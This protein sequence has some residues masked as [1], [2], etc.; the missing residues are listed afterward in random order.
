MT[1]SQVFRKSSELDRVSSDSDQQY[2]TVP[3][4]GWSGLALNFWLFYALLSTSPTSDSD[5]YLARNG[6]THGC[7]SVSAQSVSDRSG[8]SD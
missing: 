2:R 1:S 3:L 6:P 5:I 4:L 8:D 7:P